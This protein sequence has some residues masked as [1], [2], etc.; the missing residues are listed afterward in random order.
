MFPLH[1]CPRGR[2][3][4]LDVTMGGPSSLR[5]RPMPNVCL[6]EMRGVAHSEADVRRVLMLLPDGLSDYEISR[7]TRIP[8]S[9][10]L[11]W[12]H[13]DL[14]EARTGSPRCPRCGGSAHDFASLPGAEHAYLL[15]KYLGDGTIYRAGRSHALRI[16][17]DAQYTRIIEECCDVIET[18]WGGA[19]TYGATPTSGSRASPRMEGV[20]P[21]SFRSMDQA[22]STIARSGWP[23]GRS[24]LLSRIPVR[25]SAA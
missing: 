20:A 16:S 9:T 10:V 6:A 22:V 21:A 11:R 23:S 4:S 2:R 12:R 24:S 13:G 1:Q 25:F 15:D 18:I 5:F 8:R 17:S 14:P 7:R 19:R 3:P